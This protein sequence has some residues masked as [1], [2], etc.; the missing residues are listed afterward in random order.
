MLR[1]GGAGVFFF[2]QTTWPVVRAGST[3]ENFKASHKM[4]NWPPL[5]RPLGRYFQ[6]LPEYHK[7]RI[8]KE[9]WLDSEVR[10]HHIHYVNQLNRVFD[11]LLA[12]E[13]NGGAALCYTSSGTKSIHSLIKDLIRKREPI[14]S[15]LNAVWIKE[16]ADLV[17]IYPS[18][19]AI[20]ALT[21]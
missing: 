1:F 19:P 7:Y 11:L 4:D 8:S 9:K 6:S 15:S 16:A 12:I 10:Y 18:A 17:E 21:A 3:W 2:F 5:D 13:A 20:Q 14:E